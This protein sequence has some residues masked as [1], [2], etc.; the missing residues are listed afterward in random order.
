MSSPDPAVDE[1]PP[2]GLG[3]F[4]LVEGVHVDTAH[5]GGGVGEGRG[6]L[7]EKISGGVAAGREEAAEQ[8]ALG[9]WAADP[10]RR[11]ALGADPG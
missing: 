6:Q 3:L 9:A 2:P 5:P 8:A 7:L 4:Q 1:L 10:D 11:A